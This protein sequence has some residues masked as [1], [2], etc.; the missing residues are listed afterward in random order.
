MEKTKKLTK[1]VAFGELLKLVGDNEKLTKFIEHEIELLDNKK[2]KSGQTKTQK[3]NVQCVESIFETLV[4]IGKSTIKQIQENNEKVKDF[5]SQKMSALMKK[6][7]DSGR[8]VKTN[9]KKLTLYEVVS[10]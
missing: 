9:E 6:L 2:A 1:R 4:N 8:V 10:E 3:E 5:S 7:V